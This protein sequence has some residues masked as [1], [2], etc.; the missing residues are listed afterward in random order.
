M[1]FQRSLLCVQQ[2]STG[3]YPESDES[4][5]QPPSILL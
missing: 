5:L 4:I 3:P 2:P 1:E